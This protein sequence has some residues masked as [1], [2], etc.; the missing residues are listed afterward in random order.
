MGRHVPRRL[1]GCRP[2]HRHLGRGRRRH[3]QALQA[4]DL[5][6]NSAD[7]SL[8][9]P[10]AAFQDGS[11]DDALGSLATNAGSLALSGGRD[12]AVSGQFANDGT[13]SLGAGSE[14]SV[15]EVFYAGNGRIEIAIAG[16]GIAAHGRVTGGGTAWLGG[17]IATSFVAP[18]S[19]APE[20]QFEVLDA[21][22]L[23]GSVASVEGGLFPVYDRAGGRVLPAATDPF[24]GCTAVFGGGAGTTEWSSPSNWEAGEVPTGDDTACIPEGRTVDFY[25]PWP[26]APSSTPSKDRGVS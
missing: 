10:A 20:D 21:T 6:T 26:P 19:P 16:T 12:L 8:L 9:G 2:E 4:N 15:A 1:R 23:M 18:F 13:L 11:G 3:P 25:G 24:P 7:I 14:L 5:S 22:S 17:T